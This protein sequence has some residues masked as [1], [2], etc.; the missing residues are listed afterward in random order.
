MLSEIEEII[1]YPNQQ[2]S[3]QQRVRKMWLERLLGARQDPAVWQP[4]IK[5]YSPLEADCP[6]SKPCAFSR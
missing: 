5:V 3:E 4:L 1:R 6:D 2:P